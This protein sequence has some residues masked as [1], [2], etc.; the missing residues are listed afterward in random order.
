MNV[1]QRLGVASAVRVDE[2][3]ASWLPHAARYGMPRSIRHFSGDWNNAGVAV[4]E[5]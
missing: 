4:P 2:P 5:G 3:P 1:Y